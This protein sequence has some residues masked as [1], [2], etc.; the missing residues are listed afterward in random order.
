MRPLSGKARFMATG[1]RSV[2]KLER[3]WFQV[4]ALLGPAVIRLISYGLM[5]SLSWFLGRPIPA[6]VV[7]RAIAVLCCS[8][9][10]PLN[11]DLG[12]LR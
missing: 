9:E 12:V 3:L 10:S 1:V 8:P 11:N 5:F 2:Q 4:S 6:P 7:G